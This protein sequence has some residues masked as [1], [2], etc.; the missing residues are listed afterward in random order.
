MK[1]STP[2]KRGEVVGAI[3]VARGE[4][5]LRAVVE[6][7]NVVEDQ[8]LSPHLDPRQARH[9]GL[10]VAV[11]ARPNR[12]PPD[13]QSDKGETAGRERP[14]ERAQPQKDRQRTQCVDCGEPGPQPSWIGPGE[15]KGKRPPRGHQDDGYAHCDYYR[16]FHV[17]LAL[18]IE[19]C[20]G[21]ATLADDDISPARDT[22]L[23]T[24]ISH[25]IQAGWKR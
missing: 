1:T 13:E 2:R 6:V 22:R 3:L 17:R 7:A 4:V 19:S 24:I 8:L 23:P 16:A 5:A 21:L 11:V 12:A 20:V 15:Y 10:P 9:I 25:P 18:A 14:G